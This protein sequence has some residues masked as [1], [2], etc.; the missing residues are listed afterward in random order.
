MHEMSMRQWAEFCSAVE[1]ASQMI[2]VRRAIE[3]VYLCLQDAIDLRRPVCVT[4]GRCCRF[5]EYGHRL[6]VTTMELAT[7]VHELRHAGSLPD[8]SFESTGCPFQI[9][10]LCSVHSIRPFG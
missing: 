5:D 3:N 9:G 6:F 10:K 1:R 4:S 8:G 2:D 7:F